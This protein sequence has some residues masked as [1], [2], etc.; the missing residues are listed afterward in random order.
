MRTLYY[1]ALLF[2]IFACSKDDKVTLVASLDAFHSIEVNSTFEI[3]LQE[4]NS[5]YIEI[6]GVEDF[7]ESV[8]YEV[9]DGILKLDENSNSKWTHPTDKQVIIVVHAP[10]LKLVTM[11]ET[12]LLKT[13]TPITSNEFGLIMKGKSNTADLDLQG[14]IFY[15]W[16]NFPTGGIITLRGNVQELKIWNTGIMTVDAR[17]LNAPFAQIE[18]D[19][20]SDCIVTV[21]QHI[22][23]AIKDEGNIHLYGNPPNQEQIDHSGSGE[24]IVH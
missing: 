9:I 5:Y 3:Q 16:N 17:E 12:S 19:A 23:W 13:I 10:P 20:E 18:N 4:D 24:F 7:A 11:N 21:S 2:I 6:I 1:I 15:Y 22:R 14:N 8:L